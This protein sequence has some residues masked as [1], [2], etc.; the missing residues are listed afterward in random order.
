MILNRSHG[1]DIAGVNAMRRAEL[2]GQIELPG[3]SVDGDDLARADDP[4]ALQGGE[5]DAPAADDGH[6]RPGR[7]VHC[8]QRGPEARGDAAANQ[9]GAIQ[10][11]VVSNLHQ[12]AFGREHLLGKR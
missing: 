4:R 12:R 7:D 3:L 11:H 8:V 10:G 2:L 1:I 6:A 9:A 5:A